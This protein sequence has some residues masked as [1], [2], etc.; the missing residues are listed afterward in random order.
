MNVEI[1]TEAALFPEK[2]DING[3]F[4]AVCIYSLTKILGSIINIL[5]LFSS[6]F[7]TVYRLWPSFCYWKFSNFRTRN[8]I[9]TN[10]R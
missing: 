5:A 3:I 7:N 2:E 4:V 9:S 1:G 10:F 8:N 6:L